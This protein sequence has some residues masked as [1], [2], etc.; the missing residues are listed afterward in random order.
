MVFDEFADKVKMVRSSDLGQY[1]QQGY[2]QYLPDEMEG[3]RR[4]R[5]SKVAVDDFVRLRTAVDLEGGAE[6]FL[7]TLLSKAI[8]RF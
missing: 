1:L 4:A 2:Q 6:S 8:R 3:G 7:Q 5:L